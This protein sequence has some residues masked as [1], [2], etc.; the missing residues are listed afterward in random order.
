MQEEADFVARYSWFMA[1][2]SHAGERLRE[3][4]ATGWYLSRDGNLCVG[5]KV[6]CAVKEQI[7][8]S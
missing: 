2:W 6:K 8:G 1:K 4:P 5:V 7:H 3:D